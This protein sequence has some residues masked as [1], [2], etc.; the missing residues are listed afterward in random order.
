MHHTAHL[1]LP[2]HSLL[3]A[4]QPTHSPTPLPKKKAEFLRNHDQAMADLEARGVKMHPLALVLDNVRSAYNVG[5]IFRTAETALVAE[6][7]TAGFTPHP[8]H[9]KLKKT[10]TVS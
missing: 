4:T 6:V 1:P 8:P 5:S 2:Y 9:D 7:V 3:L 10:G